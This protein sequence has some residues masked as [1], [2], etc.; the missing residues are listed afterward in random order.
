MGER[1][2]LITAPRLMFTCVHL[3]GSRGAAD[4]CRGPPGGGSRFTW[5]STGANASQS[6]VCKACR[7]MEEIGT[8]TLLS[9]KIYFPKT[10]I[11]KQCSS[12]RKLYLGEGF[13]PSDSLGSPSNPYRTF[14]FLP[15][16][17]ENPHLSRTL[18]GSPTVSGHLTGFCWLEDSFC[19]KNPRK[20]LDLRGDGWDHPYGSPDSCSSWADSRTCHF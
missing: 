16:Q 6:N 7:K 4:A 10:P 8:F 19:K 12:N 18:A 5:S 17:S 1:R 2:V 15:M 9:R 14:Q 11:K 3:H 20:M 13:L